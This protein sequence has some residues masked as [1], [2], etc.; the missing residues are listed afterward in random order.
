LAQSARRGRLLCSVHEL[1]EGHVEALRAACIAVW[2][3][4]CRRDTV[5]PSG[6]QAIPSELAT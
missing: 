2:R 4:S 6:K 5:I 1:L 3:G